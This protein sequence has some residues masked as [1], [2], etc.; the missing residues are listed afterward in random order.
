MMPGAAGTRCWSTRDAEAASC[1]LGSIGGSFGDGVP[2]D[3]CQAGKRLR[4]SDE[5]RLA[6]TPRRYSAVVAS[7]LAESAGAGSVKEPLDRAA[8]VIPGGRPDAGPS[9]SG[10]T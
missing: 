10:P 1:E 2:C 4:V 9:V 3:Q 6:P 8:E 5:C 7:G